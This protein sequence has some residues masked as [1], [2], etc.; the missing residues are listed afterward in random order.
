[1]E[2]QEW[3]C[4]SVR[5]LCRL[6]CLSMGQCINKTCEYS[7]LR[8]GVGVRCPRVVL[9]TAVLAHPSPVRESFLPPFQVLPPLVVPM[10]M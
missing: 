3:V 8:F 6:P 7:R 1:M 2:A 5:H 9:P 4:W 10:E